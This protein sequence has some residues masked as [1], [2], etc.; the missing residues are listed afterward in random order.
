MVI[1][2]LSSICFLG[3]LVF[4]EESLASKDMKKIVPKNILKDIV[5]MLSS[6]HYMSGNLIGYLLF[7][8]VLIF[9]ANLSIIFIDYMGVP[10]EIYGWYQS[11]I[12]GSFALTSIVS[13]WMIGRL[14]TRIT[15]YIGLF[16]SFIG[17]VCLLFSA[18]NNASPLMICSIMALYT[19][20]GTLAMVIYC[21]EG[22]AVFP[23][24]KGVATGLSN[25]LR[26]LS[27]G[28]VI[29]IGASLFD[30][31][32][33]PIAYLGMCMFVIVIILALLIERFPLKNQV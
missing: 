16:I 20:G 10:Q 12:I 29:A 11:M 22:V 14:G 30:G 17:V 7:A 5:K 31:S 3:S 1:A 26:H 28:F 18:L 33:K 8:I 4:I 13:P 25:M 32:I 6:L 27:I 24:M 23:D 9:I 2:V 19:V 15:K 21:V